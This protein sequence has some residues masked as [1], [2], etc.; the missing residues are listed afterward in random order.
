M[1]LR[2]ILTALSIILALTSCSQYSKLLKTGTL[3][4]KYDQANI[5]FEQGKYNKTITLY[6]NI[7]PF[8][9]GSS[10]ED[11][12]LFRIGKAHY[13]SQNYEMSYQYFD[14]YRNKFARM[15]LSQ[16]A[17]LLYARSFANLSL[18]PEKDQQET[19]KAITSYNEYLNRYPKDTNRVEIE[20]EIEDL[21]KK[22]YYKT[23]LNAALYYKIGQYNAAITALRAALKENPET[24]HRQEMMFL[25]TRSWYDYARGSI[26][27]KQ[28]DR[29]LKMID[30][31]YNFKGEYPESEKF[32][33]QLDQIYR[34][35]LNFTEK[36]G[37]KSKELRDAAKFISEMQTQIYDNKDKLFEVRDKNER[38]KIKKEIKELRAKIKIEK[39]RLKADKKELEAGREKVIK[40]DIVQTKQ[41]KKEKPGKDKTKNNKNKDKK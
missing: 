37:T 5:Y 17:E 27:S 7:L 8:L 15:P 25:I 2:Y 35:A 30:S 21:T 19:K 38:L 24:P 14:E 33:K 31:Y 10:R 28:L 26:P 4:Q 34:Q 22:L 23:F 3:Q 16:E 6:T 12:I 29:Y 32:D 41:A 13:N 39:T 40:Q 1:R 20:Q 11:T 36:N 18:S 9:M